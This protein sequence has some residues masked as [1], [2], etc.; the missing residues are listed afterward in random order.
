MA[1]AF[2]LRVRPQLLDSVAVEKSV[3]AQMLMVEVDLDPYGEASVDTLIAAWLPLTYAV[4]SLNRCMGATDLHPFVLS[5]PT[6]AKLGFIH[7]LVHS[8]RA[9]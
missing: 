4:N 8:P 3:A 2:G 9:K 6:I 1:A 5:A 7:Q